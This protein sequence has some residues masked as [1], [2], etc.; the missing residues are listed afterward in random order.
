MRRPTAALFAALGVAAGCGKDAPVEPAAAPD[1]APAAARTAAGPRPDNPFAPPVVVNPNG[2]PPP[3]AKEQPPAPKPAP[4]APPFVVYNPK[5]AD[6]APA[7][8]PTA[9]PAD[10]PAE[11]TGPAPAPPVLP[12]PP[13]PPAKPPEPKEKTIGSTKV[14]DWPTEIGGKKPADYVKDLTDLDPYIRQFALRALPNFGPSVRKEPGLAKGI[15]ARMDYLKELDPGVRAA[16]FEAAGAIGFEDARDFD[17]AVRLLFVTADQGAKGGA[18][19]LYAVN[20]LTTVG[21]RAFKAVPFLIGGP[22][23]DPAYETRAAVATCLGAVAAQEGTGP[24]P[25]AL[26]C[27]AEKLAH[28]RSAAVRLAAMQSLVVLGPPMAPRPTLPPGSPPLPPNDPRMAP[29]RDEAATAALTASIRRRLVPAK[30]DKGGATGL[31]EKDPQVEVFARLALMRFDPKEADDANLS[32][33]TKYLAAGTD[34]G[35]KLVALNALTT[36]GG[37]PAARKVDDVVKALGDEHPSVAAAAATALVA[38]G[39][40]AKGAIPAL[41]KLKDRPG[42]K[43]EKEQW[44]KLSA[45]AVRLIREAGKPPAPAPPPAGKDGKKA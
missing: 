26:T 16:A 36:L 28:D 40:R 25:K 14:I 19:R 35:I 7:Q 6:P 20:A 42:T 2:P 32:G 4:A 30:G 41:E 39:D 24:S 21:P 33:I 34:T 10:P 8:V 38:M 1:P 13:P 23:E 15:L 12:A 17:E 18:S 27:L 5:P 29:K 22:A 44:A 31:V 3:A 11:S 37:E 43:E 45:E 9:K